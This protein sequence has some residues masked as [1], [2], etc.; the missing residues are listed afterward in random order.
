MGESRVLSGGLFVKLSVFTVL[1]Q[2]LSF[3]EMLDKLSEM[4]VEV[5]EL[6]AGNYPGNSHW[7][8]L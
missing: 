4:G 2:N 5:V 6:G 1:Y 7:S 3:E 8:Q